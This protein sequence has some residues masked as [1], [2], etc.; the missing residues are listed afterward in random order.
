MLGKTFDSETQITATPNLLAKFNILL[1]T[2][3]VT[4]SKKWTVSVI[5]GLYLWRM[6][7]STILILLY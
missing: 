2:V 7:S 1:D 6:Y 4:G 5:N 3:P